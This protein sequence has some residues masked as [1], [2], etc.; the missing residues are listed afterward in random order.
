MPAA[1]GKAGRRARGRHQVIAPPVVAHFV[2][3]VHSQGVD[4]VGVAVVAVADDAAVRGA[5]AARLDG[6]FDGVWRVAS[7]ERRGA[8]HGGIVTGGAVKCELIIDCEHDAIGGG[9]VG[10]VGGADSVCLGGDGAGGGGEGG[11][12]GAEGVGG[13]DDGLG[14]G[15]AGSGGVGGSG[16]GKHAATHRFGHAPRT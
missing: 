6:C 11:G 1:I 2:K 5:G 4:R 15:R 12:G 3:S 13:G 9:E 10:G 7:G 8:T 14:G 16:G